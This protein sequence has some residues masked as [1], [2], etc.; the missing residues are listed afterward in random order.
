MAKRKNKKT[1]LIIAI[2]VLVLIA[3]AFFYFKFSGYVVSSNST[4]N[5]NCNL[6]DRKCNSNL[7]NSFVCADWN[8]DGCLKWQN[9][10][11][12]NLCSLGCD[13][14][15]GKCKVADCTSKCFVLGQRKCNIKTNNSLACR[16]WNKDGCLEWEQVSP[17]NVCIL[18]CNNATGNCKSNFCSEDC[19]SIGQKRCFDN[20]KYKQE[21]GYFDGDVCLDWKAPVYCSNKC[22][23]KTGECN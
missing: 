6:G 11:P 18:G 8:K 13:A 23:S 5:N 22:N 4:C 12:N 16:D 15:T 10:N 1:I 9:A 19:N 2:I 21:C 3:I 7:N 14:K 17:N 20:N